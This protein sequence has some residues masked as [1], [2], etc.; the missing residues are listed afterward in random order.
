MNTVEYTSHYSLWSLVKAPL[1]IGCDITNMSNDTFTILTNKEVI[2][3]NQD[4]LG[5]QGIKVSTN[6]DLG[7]FFIFFY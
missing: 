6:G 7:I 2:A 5:I 3:V 4:P 1:I